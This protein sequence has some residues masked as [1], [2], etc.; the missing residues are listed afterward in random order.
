MGL[1]TRKWMRTMTRS[2]LPVRCRMKR[3]LMRCWRSSGGLPGSFSPFASSALSYLTALAIPETWA[4]WTVGSWASRLRLGEG[5]VA[6]ELGVQ[7][8]EHSHL[9][10]AQPGIGAQQIRDQPGVVIAHRLHELAYPRGLVDVTHPHP[11]GHQVET[12][13]GVAQPGGE[14]FV[15]V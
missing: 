1:A 3:Y 8:R 7:H 14:R 2:S 4:C 5:G 6:A 13:E 15:L 10:I 11:R 12:V 9:G